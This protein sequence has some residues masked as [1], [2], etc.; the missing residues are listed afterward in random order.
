MIMRIS[1]VMLLGLIGFVSLAIGED[2]SEPVYFADANLKAAVE[3]ALGISDPTIIDML[4]LSELL[5]YD[6]DIAS[7]SG[8]EYA[9]NL[10]LLDLSENQI[11]DLSPL[12]GLSNLI[13]LDLSGNE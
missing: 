4:E 1:F 8:L 6:Q 5:A 9:N 3:D 12:A 2:Q 13:R 11:S 7:L 10:S